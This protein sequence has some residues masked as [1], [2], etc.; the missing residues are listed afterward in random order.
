VDAHL[1]MADNATHGRDP[2]LPAESQ[3]RSGNEIATVGLPDL[4]DGNVRLV[5][6]TI[7]CEPADE[8]RPGYRTADE[9]RTQA[10]TQREWYRM[11]EREDLLRFVTRREDI[12]DPTQMPTDESPQY[13]QQAIL[14]LEGGDALRSPLDLQEWFDAGL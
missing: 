4:R 8:K 3:P 11:L 10:L 12:P 1:G 5:C 2:R 13:L 6:A 14:L 7:F 9:A